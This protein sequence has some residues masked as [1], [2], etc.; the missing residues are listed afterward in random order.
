MVKEIPNLY[1]DTSAYYSTFVLG[2][3]INE[4]PEKCIFGVDRPFGDLVLSKEAILKV[5]KTAS[6]ADAVLGGNIERLLKP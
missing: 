1:L 4:L 5:A 3:V 6:I 2:I